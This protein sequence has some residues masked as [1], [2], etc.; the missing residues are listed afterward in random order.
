M[1]PP[2]PPGRPPAPPP[3]EGSPLEVAR[4]DMGAAGVDVPEAEPA[5]MMVGNSE[6]MAE[7]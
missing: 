5:G 6:D 1:D 2:P 3:D 7:G 4:R